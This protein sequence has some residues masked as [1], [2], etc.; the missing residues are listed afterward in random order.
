MSDMFL[1]YVP[2]DPTWRPTPE[3]AERACARL[4]TFVPRA[5][6]VEFDFKDEVEFFPPG[7]NWSGVTCPACGADLQDWWND[8]MDAADEDDF[9][10]LAVTPPCCGRPANL[11]D[12][13]YVWAAAFGVFVLE[14]MNPDILDTTPEQDAAI[15]EILGAPLRK[16]W[17]RV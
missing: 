7:E 14:A 11:N 17:V 16:V 12:L 15:A 10:D 2:A 5:E 6:T 8:A 3:A 1:Q 4:A 13:D 9:S